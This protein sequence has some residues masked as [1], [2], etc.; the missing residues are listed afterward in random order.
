MHFT[1]EE[2]RQLQEEFGESLRKGQSG[3]GPEAPTLAEI[4]DWMVRNHVEHP[5]VLEAALHKLG[6]G[7]AAGEKKMP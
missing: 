3:L 4:Q 5:R 6:P 1:E 2:I 7:H